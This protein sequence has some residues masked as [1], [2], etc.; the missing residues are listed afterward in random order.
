MLLI[1]MLAITVKPYTSFTMRNFLVAFHKLCDALLLANDSLRHRAAFGMRYMFIGPLCMTAWGCNSNAPTVTDALPR[2]SVSEQPILDI[3]DDVLGTTESAGDVHGATRLPDGGIV[4]ADRQ[5]SSLRFFDA[6]GVFVR[7]VGRKGRGPSEFVN[8]SH[9]LRCG[10]SLFVYDNGSY[11]VYA[12]NGV[13]HRQFKLAGPGPRDNA[14]RSAC[15]ANGMLISYGWD[16]LED[17]PQKS[18]VQRKL[19]PYWLSTS[20]GTMLASLGQWW[21]SERWATITSTVSGTGPLPLGKQPVVAI[22]HARA[23]IGVADSFAIEVFALGGA[24][25]STL[26]RRVAIRKSTPA[27]IARFKQL[28]TMGRSASDNAKTL[29]HW[30][31]MQLPETLPPYSAALVDSDDNLW[32]RIFPA[33]TDAY[34]TWLGFTPTGEPL[35]QLALPLALEVDEIGHDYI[36]G[37]ETDL[38]TG[39]RR[40]KLFALLQSK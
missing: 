32:V 16:R 22:G 31:E 11:R 26:H 5:S 38:Q 30:S 9:M 21:S 36:L 12:L 37:T 15:N 19:V 17:L 1:M 7:S 25:S 2:W 13:L 39:I 18:S 33:A 35:A 40:V 24:H 14:Y 10:D 8:L 4:V 29:Q 27:D 28:D 6:K 20:D 23:Y 34:S 3:G